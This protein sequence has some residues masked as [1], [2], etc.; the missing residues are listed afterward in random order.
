MRILAI[1]TS[2]DETAVSVI[3]TSGDWNTPGFS[4]SILGNTLY[5]Q[6]ATH[7]PYGGVFP[8][9]A[10]REHA[11]NIV[12]LL[13]SALKE[14]PTTHNPVH[15][16]DLTSLFTHEQDAVAM[17]QNFFATQPR[18]AI[19]AVVVTHGPGLEPALWVG[20]N[21][22]RALSESWGI[23]LLGVNHMEGH[24]AIAPVNPGEPLTVTP[25]SFPSLALLI[26]GG[27][28]EIVSIATWGSY[29]VIGSTR[30]DAIGEAFDKVARLI[31][32]PYP[33]GPAISRLAAQARA[34]G[35]KNTIVF[36]RP[37]RDSGD[38]DFSFSGL[39][40][41]VRRHTETFTLPLTDEQKED[42]SWAFEDAAI[43]VIVHKM[44]LALSRD[45]Y[46]DVLVGGGVAANTYLTQSLLSMISKQFPETK[47]HIPHI[48]HATDN[49]LM[50]TLAAVHHLEKKESSDPSTLRA[51]GNLSLSQR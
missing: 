36:P 33:G 11:L 47:V 29:E 1:E 28:T 49:A 18:P 32:L 43:D 44:K 35:R 31:G 4:F 19:D 3:E 51:Q 40:T 50:I 2:C 45:Q 13:T 48:S 23:P 9:L 5:S 7:A 14:V 27:H 46:H 17:F 34:S 41:A 42:I 20:I 22:A 8:A 26:S 15:S 38:L 6:V 24:I 30:D 12:P 39:K 37:M 25:I 10:K 16:I 21:A